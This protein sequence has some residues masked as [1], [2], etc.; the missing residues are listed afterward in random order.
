MVLLTN[1]HNPTGTVFTRSQLTAL[2]E[3][4]VERDLILV[5]DQAFE[6]SVFDGREMVSMASLPGMWNVP[7]LCS[8]SPGM[9]LSGLRV[10]YLVADDRIMDVLFGC[11]VNVIGATN[12][13]FQAAAVEAFRNPDFIQ[14]YN[15]I[16]DRRRKRVFE[17]L[18]GIPGVRLSLP[19]SAFLTW[20]DVS[21]PGTAP[22]VAAYLLE[23]AKVFVNDGTPYGTLGD[24]SA[25]STA[26][27]GMT[28]VSML[29]WKESAMPC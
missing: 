13:A 18:S 14:E 22:E 17:L 20:I 25:S 10:G 28:S 19:E 6:D 8:P 21:A 29:Q 4:I 24:I 9:G 11:A 12:T 1:P 15:E 26:V 16:F 23:H 27:S 5:V 3:F 7:S 2:A